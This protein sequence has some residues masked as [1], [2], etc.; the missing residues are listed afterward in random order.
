MLRPRLD[1]GCICV[2]V[3]AIC[4]R[5]SRYRAVCLTTWEMRLLVLGIAAFKLSGAPE[6]MAFPLCALLSQHRIVA[7]I[8][9]R[10]QHKGEM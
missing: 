9:I 1:V 7:A 10:Q 3:H 4:F 6:E 5:A 8:S 2:A